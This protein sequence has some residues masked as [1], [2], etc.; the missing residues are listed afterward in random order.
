MK[1][2]T[3]AIALT[4]LHLASSFARADLVLTQH[5]FAGEQKT[6]GKIVTSI[7]G[8]KIRTDNDT[9]SSA[10]I[11]TDTGD[12][13]TLVHEQKMAM[14]S[15]TKQ[16]QALLPKDAQQMKIPETKLTATGKHE[17]IDGNDCEI[18]TS[19]NSGMVVKMWIARNY[20]GYE[21][22]KEALKPMLKMAAPGAPKAPE[23]PG[24]MIKS[25]FEQSGLK[26]VTKLV[27]VEEKTLSDDLFKA[28]A[29]YKAPGQ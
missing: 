5:M 15:N 21:K 9:A 8:G 16:L 23:T 3:I 13:T 18:Y 14:T 17:T 19:E 29:D 11:D 7:K 6:P 2:S 25:E 27:S 28:P 24:M 1:A 4:V 10:I 20:P 22:L 12:M 26:F